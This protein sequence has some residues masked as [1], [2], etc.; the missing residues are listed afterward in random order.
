MKIPN[1]IVVP[2]TEDDIP[3]IGTFLQQSKLQLAINRFVIQDWPNE[4]F[5]KTHYTVKGGLADPQTTTLKVINTVSGRPVA[6]V[7]YTRT[8]THA[9]PEAKATTPIETP[10]G[11]VPEV[12]AAVVNA[13]GELK[14]SFDS[15]EFIDITHIYVE[16]SSRGKGIGSELVEIAHNVAKET[17]LPFSIC[18]E[19][20]FHGF[21]VN[22]GFRDVNHVDID[23]TQW[24]APSSGYGAFRIS[25]MVME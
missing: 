14:P 16:P 13:I 24:S 22:R 3:I 9:D 8:K 20:N 18:A 4:Q 1:H 11:I 7:V 15:D 12:Y 25:R 6:Y 5:Q 10:P 2:A 23:L 21:F 17:N 19:P